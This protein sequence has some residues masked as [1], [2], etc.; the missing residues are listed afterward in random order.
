VD[1]TQRDIYV[2]NADGSNET[3]LTSEPLEDSF[4][5]W[6][7][8]SSTIA[9]TTNRDA[10][11]FSSSCYSIYVMNADGTDQHL[12]TGNH[13]G[14]FDPGWSPDGSKIAFISYRDG[15]YEIYTISPDGSGETR[16]TNN[17]ASDIS[18]AWS[19]DSS[20]LA[21]GRDIGQ[22][23]IYLASPDGAGERL[24]TTGADPAWQPLVRSAFASATEFCR[25][26]REAVGQTAFKERYGR[27]ALRTCVVQAGD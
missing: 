11:C 12:L 27:G 8:D 14:D 18:F 6:S 25:A 15:N 19:P 20:E 2:M 4:P 9:F 16:V 26:Q 10:A 3:R 17:A 5:T 13:G 23:E 21:V 24:L 1:L 22:G 7:A